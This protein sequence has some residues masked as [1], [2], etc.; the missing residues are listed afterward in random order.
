MLRHHRFIPIFDKF[1]L[2][3]RIYKSTENGKF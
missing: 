2:R 3:M 1:P